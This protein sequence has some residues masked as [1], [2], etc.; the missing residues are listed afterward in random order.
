LFVPQRSY[1][2]IGSLR[3]ALCYPDAVGIDDTRLR[4]ALIDVGLANYVSRLDEQAHWERTLSVGEQQKL[5]FARVLLQQPDY[6]FLDEATSALDAESER[7]LYAL[8]PRRLPYTTCVSVGHRPALR[9][10]HAMRIVLSPHAVQAAAEE[11]LP[12]AATAV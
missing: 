9:E 10:F 3:D 5:A 8:L 1:L 6:V 7:Q 4:Q 11:S 2:P 12:W